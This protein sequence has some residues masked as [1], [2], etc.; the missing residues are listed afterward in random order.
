MT[1]P[2]KI[3]NEINIF[4]DGSCNPVHKIGGWAAI[5]IFDEQE[6]LLKGKEL[7]TTNNRMELLSVIKSLEYLE[8][9]D[10]TDRRIII[11][12]D[13]QY[14]VKLLERKE[15]IITNN[16]LTKKG[17]AVQNKD[18]VK[19][20]FN[21]AEALNIYFVKVKAHQ[22]E[23]DFRNFNRDVDKI[24]RKIVREYVRKNCST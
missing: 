16:F 21:F 8:K 12:S 13:S 15:K 14:A 9:Q 3:K 22:K 24:S 2:N 11:N 7:N 20:I 23:G 6:I 5:I 10:L 18:F 19:K 17:N 1:E 4:T